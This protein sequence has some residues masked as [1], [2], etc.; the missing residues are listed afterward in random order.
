[1]V[2][3]KGDRLA[4]PLMQAFRAAHQARDA[5]ARDDVREGGE[6]VLSSRRTSSRTPISESELRKI[7]IADVGALLNTV[8]F[9]SAQ[10]LSE[11]PEVAKSIL[12]FGFPDLTRLSIDEDAVFGIARELEAA[13]RDFEPRLVRGSI[14]ARR[15]ETVSPDELR[16]R[17]LV[18]AALKMRP[19]DVPVQFVAEVELDSGKIKIDR[20]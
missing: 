14:K 1:M 18:G 11:A 6:R 5:K 9:N 20:L 2:D 17:F 4:A 16:V 8:N 19:V 10:D 3:P 13:L 7:V 15:D 12:N